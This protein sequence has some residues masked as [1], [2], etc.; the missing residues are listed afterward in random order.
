M[1]FGLRVRDQFAV[2]YVEPERLVI[3]GPVKN[4]L[5][6]GQT[7]FRKAF[8]NDGVLQWRPEDFRELLHNQPHRHIQ[9]A[10]LEEELIK[11]LG[12]HGRG[13]R[14]TEFVHGDK[15]GNVRVQPSPDL[16]EDI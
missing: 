13:E 5:R 2:G 12:G 6:V 3:R 7:D 4:C 8:L 16:P 15:H 14:L 1:G 10:S 11:S 9:L